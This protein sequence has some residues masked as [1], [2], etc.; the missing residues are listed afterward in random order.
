MNTFYKAH[1]FF[2]VAQRKQ[3]S[4][5]IDKS[6]IIITERMRETHSC[7]EVTA[8]FKLLQGHGAEKCPQEKNEGHQSDV[9]HI[10]AAVAHQVA[11]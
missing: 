7:G 2:K 5:Y 4:F 3:F 6:V 9:G 1:A 11:S 10:T 8:G